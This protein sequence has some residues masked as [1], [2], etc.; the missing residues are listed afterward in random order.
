MTSAVA[1]SFLQLTRANSRTWTVHH[2]IAQLTRLCMS[3]RTTVSSRSDRPTKPSR[4][5][6]WRVSSH[7]M[8]QRN[9]RRSPATPPTCGKSQTRSYIRCTARAK[10]VAEKSV[11][12]RPT[13]PV[14]VRTCSAS[15]ESCT[16]SDASSPMPMTDSTR[17]TATPVRSVGRN[18]ASTISTGTSASI[19]WAAMAIDRSISSI[20]TMPSKMR[21]I[22]RTPS[23][24]PRPHSSPRVVSDRAR[25]RPMDAASRS[26][27][28]PPA[29]CAPASWWQGPDPSPLAGEPV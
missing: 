2:Q 14:W 10:L 21:P 7:P 12:S 8:S 3:R 26:G 25:A 22:H 15:T 19:A 27:C 28:R 5:T 29:A 11:I 4:P 9:E 6:S 20:R 1:D 18:D 13:S 24:S 17:S 16:M 23:T